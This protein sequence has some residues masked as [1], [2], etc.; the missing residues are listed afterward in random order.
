MAVIKIHGQRVI[1]VEG[2]ADEFVPNVEAAVG[3]QGFAI[4]VS[5]GERGEWL[6]DMLW[7]ITMAYAG[8][9]SLLMSR[10]T[11]RKM[12]EAVMSKEC[13]EHKLPRIPSS[14]SGS[15]DRAQRDRLPWSSPPAAPA[16]VPSTTSKRAEKARSQLA[17]RV[18]S[19]AK[20]R[21]PN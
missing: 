5:P 11:V 18:G 8:M 10:A 15:A 2:Y 20:T 4:V 3:M 13:R 21:H 14:E 12:V 19:K 17:P 6:L 7:R 9:P 16:S 1:L